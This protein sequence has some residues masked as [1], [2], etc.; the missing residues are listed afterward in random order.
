[1]KEIEAK[2]DSEARQKLD[3]IRQKAEVA[4]KESRFGA[5]LVATDEFPPYLKN[6]RRSDE[7]EKLRA[8]W[9]SAAEAAF[10]ELDR[11]ATQAV[12][13]GRFDDARQIYRK[14]ILFDVTTTSAAAWKALRKVEEAERLAAE[15]AWKEKADHLELWIRLKDELENGNLPKA[16]DMTR[17][18]VKSF[19]SPDVRAELA[20]DEADIRRLQNLASMVEKGVQTL[21]PGQAMTFGAMQGTFKEYKDGRIMLTEGK[22]EFGHPVDRLSLQERLDL[23]MRAMDPASAETDVTLALAHFYTKRAN[24]TR[25]RQH[26]RAAQDK[27][28]DVRHLNALFE[29]MDRI[30]AEEEAKRLWAEVEDAAG[31]KRWEAANKGIS[32]LLEDYG[33]TKVVRANRGRLDELLE[34]AVAW[35]RFRDGLVFLWLPAKAQ[36]EFAGKKEWF[37]KL[38]ARGEAKFDDHGFLRLKGGAFLAPTVNESLLAQCTKTHQ[39]TIEAV[40]ETVSLEQSGP[41]RIVSFSTDAANRNFTL[42]HEGKRLILRLRVSETGRS[43]NGHE[44]TMCDIPERRSFHLAV[45]YVPNRLTCYLDGKK[46]YETEEVRG[47][48]STWEPHHFI[49]GDELKDPRSWDGTIRALAIYSRA[50][51]GKDVQESFEAC[52]RSL[53]R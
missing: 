24:L 14:A 26:I 21:K 18:A 13:A 36:R 35:P 43:G 52:Q 49:L 9:L 34:M 45:T 38:E 46:A 25:V 8:A 39:L 33:N 10:Q 7:L 11:Q 19:R 48:F 41:A 28:A 4:V 15:T 37:H 50:M 5:A 29:R 23:A 42:G 2:W 32:A 40:L 20:A 22:I 31:K 51:G 1:M 17:E 53:Q 30:K 3:E 16:L 12:S 27:G 6:K 47:D 44:V